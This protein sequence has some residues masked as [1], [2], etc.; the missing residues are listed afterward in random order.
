ML[1]LSSESPILVTFL[2][3]DFWGIE[4]VLLKRIEGTTVMFAFYGVIL[5]LFSYLM[6]YC[7]IYHSNN[8]DHEPILTSW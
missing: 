5:I 8:Y 2:F 3:V 7:F 1:F 4:T 6:I